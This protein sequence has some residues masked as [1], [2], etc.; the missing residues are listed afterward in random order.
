MR[1]E[2]CIEGILLWELII[3]NWSSLYGKYWR[4]KTRIDLKRNM[5]N[6][7]EGKRYKSDEM[8][9]D[10]KEMKEDDIAGIFMALQDF[11]K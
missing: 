8:G 1:V 7:N 10:E 3:G 2:D 5:G 4:S 9:V 11:R 6:Q